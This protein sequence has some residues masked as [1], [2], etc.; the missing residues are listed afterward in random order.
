ME[1]WLCLPRTRWNRHPT[2]SDDGW[3]PL[4]MFG[5]RHSRDWWFCPI[6]CLPQR[7]QGFSPLG[8]TGRMGMITE[9]IS[10][11][12]VESNKSKVQDEQA[13]G[14]PHAHTKRSSGI[15][16][17]R[18]RTHE[19]ERARAIASTHS[20][21]HTRAHAR[22]RALAHMNTRARMRVHAYMCMCTCTCVHAHTR[23][24]P[25]TTPLRCAVVAGAYL[26]MESSLT[27]RYVL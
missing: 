23:H 18:I 8:V 3:K 4:N 20:Q 27:L 10:P 19:R 15:V 7:I 16:G 1:W 13:L 26:W 9:T 11:P 21:E 5:V 22:A 25:S 24:P 14:R 6:C 17:V 12:C 2:R